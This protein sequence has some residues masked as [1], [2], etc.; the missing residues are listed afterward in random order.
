MGAVSIFDSF[1]PSLISLPSPWKLGSNNVVTIS[2]SANYMWPVLVFFKPLA[3][4]MKTRA[5]CCCMRR[6]TAQPVAS[7]VDQVVDRRLHYNPNGNFHKR[8]FRSRDKAKF[9]VYLVRRSKLE[10]LQR[11]TADTSSWST[12]ITKLCGSRKQFSK[13]KERSR[14][15]GQPPGV[16]LEDIQNPCGEDKCKTEECVDYETENWAVSSSGLRPDLD[17]IE[18]ELRASALPVFVDAKNVQGEL[19]GALVE[20]HFEFRHFDIRPKNLESSTQTSSKLSFSK[21]VSLL[22]HRTN[23]R[24]YLTAPYS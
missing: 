8:S 4:N 17:N 15:I 23:G 22:L 5:M 14:K 2:C 19:R 18:Y 3:G 6:R 9:E 24:M 16:Y 7:L 10:L 11:T 1:A 20:L 21:K 12:I 13:Q